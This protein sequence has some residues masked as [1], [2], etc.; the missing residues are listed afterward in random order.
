MVNVTGSTLVSWPGRWRQIH[1]RGDNGEV[2]K[3]YLTVLSH[4]GAKAFS[5]AGVLAR[6][7]MS[8]VPLCI[9]LLVEHYYGGFGL[10]GRVA[11]VYT[12]C[13]A[14]CS[15]QLAKLVDAHGQA[16]VMRP[17]LALA[18]IS[19]AA[20]VVATTS[21]AL[22]AL[23]YLTA[24][25]TGCG[26][27]SMGAMVRARWSTIVSDPRQLH[28]AFSL[29]STLDEVVFVVG[30]VLA[31]T[32][33][34][35]IN[36]AAGLIVALVATGGGGWW[37]LSQ[38][39]TEPK[40]SGRSIRDGGPSV[41]RHGPVVVVAII[42]IGVGIIFGAIDVATVAYAKDQGSP[43][44]AGPILAT[45]A[46][47]SLVA[48]FLYGA[49]TFTMPAWKRFVIGCVALSLSVCVLFLVY[50]L[51]TLTLVMFLAGLTIAPTLISGNAVVHD[52]VSAD[53]LTEGLTWV[54]TAIGVGFAIGSSVAGYAVDRFGAHESYAVVIAAGLVATVLALAGV[55]VLR[56]SEEA[57]GPDSGSGSA[58]G[59]T[60]RAG[61]KSTADGSGPAATPADDRVVPGVD[62]DS[63]RTRIPGATSNTESGAGP[64][65]G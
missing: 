42:F 13:Q 43:G 60:Q 53:R 65:P 63:G 14:I 19:L 12:V 16:K 49:R 58:D 30:P 48:G 40:S 9:V 8:M 4:R 7:P 56:R 37:F 52:T 3:P 35:L 22:S 55:P 15:P 11:A 33:A 44:L 51:A 17:A 54:G 45:L 21:Q 29:E 41:L 61:V 50:S 38:R 32:L 62:L 26:V 20:F 1:E 6:L 36:P 5:A 59:H 28:T 39:A 10:A 46:G 23:L 31:T 34:T 57:P 2:F 64:H 24:G 18:M 25:L 47:G 27:G